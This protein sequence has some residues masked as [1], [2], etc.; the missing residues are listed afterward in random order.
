MNSIYILG[1]LTADPELRT[2]PTG[3][4]VCSFTVAV[5]KPG[6]DKKADFMRVTAWDKQ[7]EK[8]AKYI[9]KGSQVLVQGEPY[10]EAFT[11]RDGKPRASLHIT[12][13]HIEFLSRPKSDTNGDILDHVNPDSL[14][15]IN[16]DDFPF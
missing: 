5:N 8:C 11:G 1:R 2:T 12:L 13:N 6:T 3:K 9:S 7:A 16:P 15:D 4:S 10:A 14:A